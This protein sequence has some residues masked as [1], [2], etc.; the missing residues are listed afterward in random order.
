[1]KTFFISSI[2]L[3]MVAVSANAQ[4]PDTT[5]VIQFASLVHDYGTINQGSDG[6]CEFKFENKGKTPLQL[7]NVRASCGCTVPTWPREPILPGNTGVIK[8]MYNTASIGSFNKSITV[9][10]NAK[11]AS[12]VLQIK[13]NVVAKPQ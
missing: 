5:K 4:A 6:G 10:S 2:L 1:M 7:N 3:F 13:G 9:D 8:V 12:V 11:N